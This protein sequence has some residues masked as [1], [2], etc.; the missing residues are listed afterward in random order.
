MTTWLLQAVIMLLYESL[1]CAEI[2]LSSSGQ[3]IS[4]ILFLHSW[5]KRLF[6][7]IELVEEGIKKTQAANWRMKTNCEPNVNQKTELNYTILLFTLSELRC[8]VCPVSFW[9]SWEGKRVLSEQSPNGFKIHLILCRYC[10][11]SLNCILWI[12]DLLNLTCVWVCKMQAQ[13]WS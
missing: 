3:V 13:C 8:L 7:F 1:W 2:V 6:K 9:C 5:K 10:V 11:I 4:R 12:M